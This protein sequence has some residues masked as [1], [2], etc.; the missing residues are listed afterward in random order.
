MIHISRRTKVIGLGVIGVAL[1]VYA[2]R[3]VIGGRAIEIV[4]PIVRAWAS[5]E[6]ARLSDGAYRLQA[7]PLRVTIAEQRVAIDSIIITTDTVRNAA[8]AAPLPTITAHYYNC[9]VE[10][11][12]LERLARR[13]GF[14]ADRAGCDSVHMIVDVPAN[15]A[16]DSAGG[17]FLSLQDN[18]DLARG[19][20]FVEVDSVVLPHVA[21]LLTMVAPNGHPTTAS[22]DHM[23]IRLEELHYDPDEAPAERRTL[24]SR[25]V[26][27]SVDSLE[28]RRESTDRMALNRLR[29]DLV[30]GTVQLSG[31]SWHPEPGELRD[32]LGLTE[33]AVDSLAV[34]GI[35]WREFLTRGNVAVHSIALM[36]A[37]L[38]L[39]SRQPT[40]GSGVYTP[41]APW[42]LAGSLGAIDR[43]VRLDSLVVTDLLLRHVTGRDTATTTVG[44]AGISSIDAA[45]NSTFEGTE[46]I[47]PM[48]IALHD[49]T[50][51]TNDR[52][53]H[54][55]TAALDLG[56]GTAVIDSLRYAPTGTDA[57]FVRRHQRR[58][59]RID[60]RVASLHL[61]GLEAGEWVRRGAYRAGLAEVNGLDVDVLSDKRLPSGSAAHRRTPQQWMQE[62]APPV[63]IDST[64][65]RGRLQYRERGRESPR[66][67]VLRFEQVTARIVNLRNILA[68]ED[69]RP[70]TANIESRLMGAAL[71]TLAI[72]LPLLDTAFVGRYTGELGAMPAAA[73]NPFIDGALGA[74]FTSGQVRGISFEADITNGTARGRV[75]P[76]YEG[77]WIELPGVARSGFLSGLR[78][79]V[80]KF[81]A[82]QFLLREDNLT[83]GS[84]APRNGPIIHKWRRDETLLQF[85][86]NGVR[87]G[88]LQVVKR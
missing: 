35:D 58:T 68:P 53:L 17:S 32:S 79:A 22:F 64:V 61:S 77:L 31:L 18:I 72:E 30:D 29:A 19:V 51:T 70:T 15:V 88:L 82:N 21:M 59:D 67:G 11:I 73:L 46:P 39:L 74:R 25:N 47:G 66:A 38:T 52:V 80:A 27:L 62:V 56:Q 49:V 69:Q 14:S 75:I 37:R 3:W 78:R 44:M 7:T 24:L 16:R 12:D 81:A 1:L 45:L 65:V 54:V 4:D 42:S 5:D 86:W 36:G 23:A 60:L 8:R 71:F 13:R 40:G 57:D 26:A 9:A 20:P 50:R 28:T 63:A 34:A 55:A 76:R 41:A 84:D 87:D 33:L 83:G 6:V 85:I 43:G 10:G 2:F 48:T